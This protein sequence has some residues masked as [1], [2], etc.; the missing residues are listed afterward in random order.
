MLL[1]A[2]QRVETLIAVTAVLFGQLDNHPRQD[3]LV[4]A[5]YESAALRRLWLYQ[6]PIEL[7]GFLVTSQLDFGLAQNMDDLLR[8]ELSFSIVSYSP[9]SARVSLISWSRLGGRSM[10]S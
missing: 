10:L 9:I 7:A 1:L 8:L 3:I 6:L 4:I 5:H 2:E